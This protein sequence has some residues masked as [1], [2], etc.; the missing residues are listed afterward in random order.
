DT[1]SL[2][3][4]E[5]LELPTGVESSPG[6]WIA[7]FKAARQAAAK[8]SGLGPAA[9]PAAAKVVQTNAGTGDVSVALRDARGLAPPVLAGATI[10][11]RTAKR[12]NHIW[13]WTLG[14]E[15]VQP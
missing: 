5:R 7:R 9:D 6:E 11:V 3:D 15:V 14:E 12:G 2:T 4:E 8:A 13:A 10:R 1:L